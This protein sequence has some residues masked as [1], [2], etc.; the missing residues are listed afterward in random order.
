MRFSSSTLIILVCLATGCLASEEW[1][2]K[3]AD[4]YFV[5]DGTSSMWGYQFRYQLGL[6]ADL[7]SEMD[8]RPD[9]TRVGLGVFS[10]IFYPAIPLNNTFDKQTL[11][12]K[13]RDTRHIKGSSVIPLGL[14]GMRQQLATNVARADVPRIGVF[15]TDGSSPTAHFTFSFNNAT[16]AKNDGIFVFV[17]GISEMVRE[18]ELVDI[19]SDPKRDF[20]Y[21]VNNFVSLGNIRQK[22]SANMAKVSLYQN[23][24]GTCGKES[25]VDTVFVYDEFDLGYHLRSA[26]QTFLTNI[27][28]DLR[29]NPG[30]IRIGV[31]SK[32]AAG[33]RHIHLGDFVT[34]EDFKQAVL[35]DFGRP[36][37]HT[38]IEEAR[39]KFFD[40]ETGHRT[41][42]KKRL[43]LIV[44]NPSLKDTAVSSKVLEQLLRARFMDQTEVFIIRHGTDY[45]KQF[46]S[47]LASS[48]DHVLYTE[49]DSA[50]EPFLSLFCKD[51]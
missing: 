35:Q 10:D 33:G 45:D 16:R 13:I 41:D 50:T 7:V 40:T 32:S 17:V 4:I 22:L 30:N 12:N 21:R 15:F 20:L 24:K 31:V 38:L 39:E 36:G 6:V 29:M 49:M 8:I 5:V 42:A 23:D 14:Q 37:I 51:I 28:D 11:M 1:Q 2:G 47:Q 9:R 44:T 43:V 26:V 18:Q 34:R 27:A 25:K 19:S 46:L 3:Q 48:P